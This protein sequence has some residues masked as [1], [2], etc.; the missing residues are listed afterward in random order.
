[1]PTVI[2]SLVV[3][4]GLDPKG[5]QTGG[6]AYRAEVKKVRDE[7]GSA[8]KDLEAYG[9][10]A[11]SFFSSLRNEAVGLF[12]AFQG[13]SSITGF[14]NDLLHGDAATGRFAAGIGMATSR[15]SAWQLAVKEMGG[16]AKDANAALGS[17][18]TMFRNY[19][20]GIDTGH[21]AELNRLGITPQIMAKGPEAM[22]LQMAKVA[23][24]MK[25]EEFQPL[26]KLLGLPDSVI[27]TLEKGR[28]GVEAL[29]REKERDGAATQADADKAAEFEKQMAKVSAHING[30]LRPAIYNLVGG[31]DKMLG[32]MDRAGTTGPIFKSVLIGIG[33]A[34]LFALAPFIALPAAIAAA[35]FAMDTFLKN[36]K[37]VTNVLDTIESPLKKFLPAWLFDRNFMSGGAASP[38]PGGDPTGGAVSGGGAGAGVG[39]TADGSNYIESNLK[40]NG[41]S[42]DQARGIRAGIAA[43][44]GGLGFSS[45]VGKHG[46]RAFGIGQWLGGRQKKLFAKYGPAPSLPQQLSF[47]M[48][49]LHGGDAGGASV[50]HGGGADDTMVRYLRDF[51]RPQGAHGER[52]IDL[53]RDI[54][55]GR[56]ALRS[57]AGGGGGSGSHTSIHI[58]KVD[59]HSNPQSVDALHKDM[60]M[61]MRRRAIAQNMNRGQG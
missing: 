51:M 31:L 60:R 39:A 19:Q 33:T 24:T 15:V 46:E 9:K 44:G 47:L 61:Q 36:H 29:I 4:L 37:A 34:A 57:N 49:E 35:V 43:E 13:A 41:F 8:G 12:L 6:A 3:E 55:R 38:A 58:A 1:M 26:A 56:N 17:L 30:I 45:F 16:D 5:A 11:S 53:T 40:R 52:M 21:N 59:V 54:G 50:M 27:Y 18:N 48:S 20:L 14:V 42:A 10:R 23:E 25:K 7:T 32:S 22:L 2:D 28:K